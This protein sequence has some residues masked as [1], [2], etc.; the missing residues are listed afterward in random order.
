ALGV[1]GEDRAA[2]DVV[3]DPAAHA[4]V[5]DVAD[6]V[7]DLGGAEQE[8]GGHRGVLDAALDGAEQVRAP[9]RALGGRVL[10]D[11]QEL[12]QAL[13]EVARV[14]VDPAGGGAAAVAGDAVAVD[15]VDAVESAPL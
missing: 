6:E 9:R 13:A 2:Q 5:D 14:R 8:E 15:A 7:V 11:R 4:Q 1:V 12:E 3:L 10:I